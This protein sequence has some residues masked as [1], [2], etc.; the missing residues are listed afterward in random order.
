[1]RLRTAT[2]E[3]LRRIV[4]AGPEIPRGEARFGGLLQTAFTSLAADVSTGGVIEQNRA[5]IL[6]L[7]IA[8]GHYRVARLV[9]LDEDSEL[10]RQAGAIGQGTTLD[11]R[12]DWPRHYALSAALAVIEHP[13]ISDAGGLM[14]EQ[15]DAL[16]RGTGFSFGDLAADRAGVRF[17]AASTRSEAAARAMQAR[18]QNGYSPGEFFPIVMDFPENLTV[19]QFRQEFGAVGSQRYRLQVSSIDRELDACDAISSR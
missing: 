19:E 9:G 14:K 4:E 17:A 3:R 1:M 16:G 10:V 12:E 13:L 7:G 11:G 5:A 18:L 6:A 2:E 8:I 15:M